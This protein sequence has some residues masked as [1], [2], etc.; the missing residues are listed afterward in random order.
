M[1]N[2][3]YIL[4]IIKFYNN[5]YI[6]LLI[7]KLFRYLFIYNININKY[8]KINLNINHYSIKRK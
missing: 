1:K 8:F 3:I 7:K 2:N 4:F 5:K 6:L